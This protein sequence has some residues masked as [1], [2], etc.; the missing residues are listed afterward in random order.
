MLSD[1]R[2][3]DPSLWPKDRKTKPKEGKT[4]ELGF[5]YTPNGSFFDFDDEYFNRNDFTLLIKNI[6]SAL[7]G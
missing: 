3:Y 2:K 7:A 6:F 1:E 4:D 5:L